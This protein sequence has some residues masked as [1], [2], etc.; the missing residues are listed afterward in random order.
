VDDFIADDNPVRVID[1]F[2]DELDLVA[3]G[4]EGADPER[5]GRPAYHPKDAEELTREA[6]QQAERSVTYSYDA[7][8]SLILRAK[9]PA[10]TGALVLKALEAA[11]N[12]VPIEQVEESLQENRAETDP[13][14]DERKLKSDQC[15]V[16]GVPMRWR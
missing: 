15:Q 13:E 3:L 8:G 5:T 6:L 11:M 2:V 7:N 1:V 16:R 12:D 14:T 9:L 10:E 4:F